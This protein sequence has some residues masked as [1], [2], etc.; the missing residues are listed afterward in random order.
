MSRLNK[1]AYAN[2]SKFFEDIFS[3]IL[4]SL[5]TVFLCKLFFNLEFNFLYTWTFI[6]F[7]PIYLICMQTQGMYQRTTF[8]YTDRV[9]RNVIV[10]CSIAF[11]FI[12]IVKPFIIMLSQQ[13]RVIG[14]YMMVVSFVLVFQNYVYIAIL[15]KYK[16]FD[17]RRVI[18]IGNRDMI[19]EYLYFINKTSFRINNIGYI[20]V[21]SD[22]IISSSTDLGRLED[23]EEILNHYIV[24]EVIFALPR[25]HVGGVNQYVKMCEQRGVTVRIVLDLFDLH[26]AKTNVHS[27]GTLPVLTYHTV[28]L[29]EMQLLTKR[30]MDIIGSIIGIL[31]TGFFSLFIIPAI[32]LDSKGPVLFSQKRVGQNGRIFKL[33]K[34]RSM[35]ANAEMMKNDYLEQNEMKDGYMFKIKND[36]RITHVG[37]FLR[38][39]SLDELPQFI[40]VLKG[41]LSVVGPRPI[42]ILS[43][44]NAS[45]EIHQ[46]YGTRTNK[47][48]SIKPGIVCIWQT[49]GRNLL[50]FEERAVLEEEYIDHQSFLLDLKII[51]KTMWVLLFPKGAY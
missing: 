30:I 8:F 36:P 46:R 15:K 10:S 44:K 51:F 32:E 24:D 3:I 7:S 6:V 1:N 20:L 9:I 2:V 37:A 41:D 49:K 35:Y 42:E 23:L 14:L 21:G 25:D 33:F 48:L 22:H 11:I 16:R 27:V 43:S 4:S 38:K 18:I 39:T 47:I 19:I 40:N 31:I 45:E 5:V 12:W 29:N 50:T 17:A 13:N 34:F 26:I 28:C